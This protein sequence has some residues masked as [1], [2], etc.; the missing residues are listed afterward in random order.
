MRHRKA[1]RKLGRTSS[2]RQALFMNLLCALF[3][4][5]KIKTTEAKGKEIKRLGDKLIS[6]AKRGDL[7]ARRIAA[8]TIVNK[9]ILAK[10]FNKI[11]PELKDRQGGGYIRLIKIGARLG[12]AAPQVIVEIVKHT[13][14]N[15]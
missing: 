14:I 2:H 1:G 5:E 9:K 6:L 10:L 15:S 4:H 12:D 8:A 3:E 13:R 11:A 7:H